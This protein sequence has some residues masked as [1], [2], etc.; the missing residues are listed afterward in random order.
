MKTTPLQNQNVKE[1]TQA[2]SLRP[3]MNAKRTVSVFAMLR[4]GT[5]MIAF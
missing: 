1:P 5:V 3:R 2:E 4:L